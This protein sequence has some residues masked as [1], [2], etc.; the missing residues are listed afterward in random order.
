MEYQYHEDG[1]LPADADSIF[2]FGSNLASIHGA[3]AAK[4]ASR[5]FGACFGAGEGMTAQI[6]SPGV[7]M[8]S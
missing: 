4:A 2:V 7:H 1:T 6:L 3:G 5:F 8:P